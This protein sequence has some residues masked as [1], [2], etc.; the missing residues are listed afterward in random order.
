MAS[1]SHQDPKVVTGLK[2]ISKVITAKKVSFLP[3]EIS[4]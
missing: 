2:I 4:N 3:K 1:S